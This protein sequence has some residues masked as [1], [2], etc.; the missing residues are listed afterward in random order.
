MN[1]RK[2]DQ[3]S[4]AW[5][6]PAIP[7]KTYKEMAKEMI[8]SGATPMGIFRAPHLDSGARLPYG[9]YSVCRY[10]SVLLI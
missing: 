1:P 7:G 6:Y 2:Y 10:T 3:E 5:A 9:T 4:M 8:Q